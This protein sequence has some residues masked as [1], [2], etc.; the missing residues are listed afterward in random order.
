MDA[1]D[2]R[3]PVSTERAVDQSQQVHVD[4]S[5]GFARASEESMDADETRWGASGGAAL[6]PP[7]F[8]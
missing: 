1:D 5:A 2:D 8:Q 6:A 3:R 7:D 4:S